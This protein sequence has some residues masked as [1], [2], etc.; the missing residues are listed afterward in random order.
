MIDFTIVGLDP[1]RGVNMENQEDE[2]DR[3]L[4][5]RIGRLEETIPVHR[6]LEENTLKD[7]LQLIL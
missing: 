1:G 5:Q 4:V 6:I 3:G 7:R 2:G